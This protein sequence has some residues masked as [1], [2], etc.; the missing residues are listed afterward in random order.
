[1]DHAPP[2]PAPEP[3][4]GSCLEVRLFYVRLS[5][6]GVGGAPPPRLALELRPAGG[7]APAIPL[8]LR[9]DRHDP[10]SG[11]ATYVSTAAAR[12]APP[13]A[14]FEVADH[15]G[16]ALLRGSLRRCTDAAKAD[17]SPAWEIDCVPA[18]GAASSAS[19]FEVYVAGCCGGEPTVLTR[20]LRLA[21][22]EE[23]AGGLVRRKL[24]AL[25]VSFAQI[26]GSL[27]A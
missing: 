16:A 11:E 27:V 5:P 17:S 19:A 18:A 22:P 4:P 12:L 23:A 2:T 24:G 9:R 26:S 1:M 14:A 25:E 8:P 15:R 21:T 7:D 13:A 20:A 3:D 6:H 10:A